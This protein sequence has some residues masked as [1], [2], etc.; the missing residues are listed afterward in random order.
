[1]WKNTI[2]LAIFLKS[3]TLTNGELKIDC[4]IMNYNDFGQNII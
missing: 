4:A 2:S 3:L 1:M